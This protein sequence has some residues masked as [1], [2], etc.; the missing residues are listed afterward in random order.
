MGFRRQVVY[1]KIDD[2]ENYGL[3]AFEGF[4]LEELFDPSGVT[5]DDS[6]TKSDMEFSD[7]VFMDEDDYG[8]GFYDSVAAQITSLVNGATSLP[9]RWTFLQELVGIYQKADITNTA[10]VSTNDAQAI[11]NFKA[12]N[13]SNTFEQDNW[14]RKHILPYNTLSQ[15]SVLTSRFDQ[16][17]WYTKYDSINDFDSIGRALVGTDSIGYHGITQWW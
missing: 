3:E 10:T 11:L 13:N 14:I 12:G 1:Q 4:D 5:F 15:P 6:D 16:N 17:K 7:A 2:L 8:N 9:E